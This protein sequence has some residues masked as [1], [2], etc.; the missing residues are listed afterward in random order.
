L[1]QQA[2]QAGFLKS[3]KRF[4]DLAVLVKPD[5]KIREIIRTHHP[6]LGKRVRFLPKTVN[7]QTVI[8]VVQQMHDE[9]IP[10]IRFKNVRR[11]SKIRR[12]A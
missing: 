4:K 6:E 1:K 9:I 8:R 3:K 2:E 12:S 11:F 5:Y 10:Y 7:G